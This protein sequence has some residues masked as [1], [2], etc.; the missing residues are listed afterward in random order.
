[1]KWKPYQEY[2]QIAKPWLNQIPASWNLSRIKY[3]TYVKGRIGWQGLRS[4]EFV[5]NGPFLVTGTDFIDGKINWQTCYH[6]TE[7]RYSEDTYIHLKNGDLLITKD[8]TIGKIAIVQGLQERATLNSGVFLTRQISKDCDTRYIYWLLNSKI[9]TNFID[10]NKSGS[11]ISHLFQNVFVEFL[12]PIPSITE[13]Q[14]IATFLDRETE[15][16][17]N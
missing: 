14:A 11:T 10:Y 17:D 12:F 3:T 16:I 5:D 8:G 2:K 15:H 1:M 4:E 13:Q 6:V 9:F 7:E